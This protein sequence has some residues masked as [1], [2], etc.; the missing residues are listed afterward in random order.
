MWSVSDSLASILAKHAFC[1]G[2]LVTFSVGFPG[3]KVVI[4]LVC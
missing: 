4:R 2:F 1:T 3:I